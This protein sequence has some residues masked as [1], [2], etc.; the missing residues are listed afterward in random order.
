MTSGA[1]APF[2]FTLTS[3]TNN[4]YKPGQKL[5]AAYSCSDPTPGAGRL[6]HVAAE[7]ATR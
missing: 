6:F 1:E 7:A 2:L 4:N 3:P 5:V